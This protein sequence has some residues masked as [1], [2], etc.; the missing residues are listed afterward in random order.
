MAFFF[1]FGATQKFHV[2]VVA[3]NFEDP[4]DVLKKSLKNGGELCS[5]VS[6]GNAR[7]VYR[8]LVHA[9]G[10]VTILRIN[11]CRIVVEIHIFSFHVRTY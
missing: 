1:L 5:Y 4:H 9:T 11:L 6:L 7:K 2:L 10:L 8:V 3:T